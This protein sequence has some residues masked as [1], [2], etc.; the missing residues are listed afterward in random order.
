[1]SEIK[2]IYGH[3][4][5][6]TVARENAA[7][8]EAN[9]I[10][11][12]LKTLAPVMTAT[13]TGAAASAGDSAARPL[14]K[15]VVY[16][17]ST[18]SAA[19][20]PSSPVD[21]VNVGDSGKVTITLAGNLASPANL[22]AATPSGTTLNGVT[23]TADGDTI[24]LDGTAEDITIFQITL[25][26]V[27]AGAPV[28]FGQVPVSGSYSG[29]VAL[30]LSAS[31]KNPTEGAIS[32]GKQL[33][34]LSEAMNRLD[35]RLDSGAVLSSWKFKPYVYV[36]PQKLPFT[37]YT[38]PVTL[39]VTA[40]GLRGLKVSSGGNYQDDS[41][42]KWLCDTIEVTD[43]GV[44]RVQRIMKLK[45]PQSGYSLNQSSDTAVQ[46]IVAVDIGENDADESLMDAEI[47]THFPQ[48]GLCRAVI[49][50]TENAARNKVF[51]RFPADVAAEL[52]VTAAEGMNA[53]M[54]D[55]D[56]YLYYPLATPIETTVSGKTLNAF[57]PVT[58]A[59]NDGVGAEEMT[60]IIDTKTYIDNK[61][62]ELATAI[63]AS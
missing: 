12:G 50:F 46:F 44:K 42:Q 29:S 30:R 39:A 18:Q 11:E 32:A 61:F 22:T 26:S 25:P 38:A 54:A 4:F 45:L 3:T 14:K 6:D 2:S 21:I 23:V 62:D 7:Q 31:G 5:N 33:D 20:S 58:T 59:F 16:G 36:S 17:K 53:F 9:A 41:G 24:T 60:Y 52:G 56:V 43:S 28:Y 48:T 13:V 47:C 49:G 37:A 63:A 35:I 10:S 19:P 34:A 51:V 55:K 15:L 1:M 8:A 57:L 40:E 27:P